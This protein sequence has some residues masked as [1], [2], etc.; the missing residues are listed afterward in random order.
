MHHAR[1]T[2]GLAALLCAAGVAAACS[3]NSDSGAHV[4]PNDGTSSAGNAGA[5]NGNGTGGG[6]N[7]I[8][9]GAAGNDDSSAGDGPLTNACAAHVST[10]QPIPLDIYLMLDVSG[11]MLDATGAQT[12]KWDAVKAA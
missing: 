3:S 1:I 5:G 12:T 7:I 6:F 11:S 4:G 2:V 8:G 9:P 10:A